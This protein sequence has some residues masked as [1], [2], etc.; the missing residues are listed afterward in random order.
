MTSL[1]QSFM[2]LPTLSFTLSHYDYPRGAFL[3]LLHPLE[4]E[5]AISG[6][7]VRTSYETTSSCLMAAE[8]LTR[9]C[10]RP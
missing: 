9:L 3:L 1:K 2:E 5:Q 7:I 10:K 4:G 8:G 6:P